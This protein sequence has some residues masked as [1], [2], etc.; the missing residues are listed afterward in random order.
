M[1]QTIALGSLPYAH[2]VHQES[3]VFPQN[4][5]SP[6]SRF[7]ASKQLDCLL[8][9]GELPQSHLMYYILIASLGSHLEVTGPEQP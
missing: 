8:D 7:V 2:V 5:H 4:S 1:R 6:A 3:V 9:Y